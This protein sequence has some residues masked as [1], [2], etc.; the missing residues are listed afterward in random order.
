MSNQISIIMIRE[1]VRR[2][3]C[4]RCGSHEVI[5]KP[6]KRGRHA[7]KAICEGC[8]EFIMWIPKVQDPSLAPPPEILARARAIRVP[9]ARL[10]GDAEEVA[11][12][13]EIRIRMVNQCRRRRDYDRVSVLR[14][15]TN[16]AWFCVNARNRYD[17][18]AW[19]TPDQLA[20]SDQSARPAAIAS[21]STDLYDRLLSLG[22]DRETPAELGWF[23]VLDDLQLGQ[24]QEGTDTPRQL[25][26]EAA[27]AKCIA[28]S[29]PH[30]PTT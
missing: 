16:A 21:P 7:G 30:S 15:I 4:K 2:S 23:A 14:A 3:P 18:I 10:I 11:L 22:E 25:E 8:G 28:D 29:A 5:E 1:A 9:V 19:P 24:D 13:A 12:A 6:I 27:P 26:L 20:A 17:K